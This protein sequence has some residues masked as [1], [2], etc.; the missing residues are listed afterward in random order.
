ML[1]LSIF[2]KGSLHFLHEEKKEFN[3][4]IVAFVS[5]DQAE[6]GGL[7][8][9]SLIG[10]VTATIFGCPPNE[11]RK[12]RKR[13]KEFPSSEIKLRSSTYLPPFQLPP[14]M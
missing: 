4:Y 9:P 14:L 7:L 2:L 8:L 6:F 10:T 12:K 5:L 11:K 1:P 3:H 13:P